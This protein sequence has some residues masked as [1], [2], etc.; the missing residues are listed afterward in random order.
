MVDSREVGIEPRG[1]STPDPTERK[2]Q[3][4]DSPKSQGSPPAVVAKAQLMSVWSRS[5]K[6]GDVCKVICHVL[7]F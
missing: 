1:E 6:V 2:P 7:R 4:G 3:G 5:D